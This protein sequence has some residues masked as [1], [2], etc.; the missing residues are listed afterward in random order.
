MQTT[1]FECLSMRINIM[2]M[3]GVDDGDQRLLD[4][5]NNH[6]Q[7]HKNG[8]SL[9]IGRQDD[10]DII[11]QNDTFVSRR[12]AKIH[13]EDQQ[14]WIED[15]K[16]TNG[17]FAENEDQFFLDKKIS[18]KFLLDTNL[19]FRVGRTWLKIKPIE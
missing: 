16:S 12:H 5:D 18:G 14:W 10:N 1:C 7:I 9:T 6:G 3:S 19:M 2:L 4:T 15:C 8:W 11:L 17:T 13:Y